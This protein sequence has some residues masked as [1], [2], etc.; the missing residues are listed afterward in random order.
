MPRKSSSVPK[1]TSRAKQAPGFLETPRLLNDEEKR[2]LIRA[3][4]A[5]RQP[6]QDPLQRLSLWAGVGLTVFVLAGGW[7]FTVGQRVQDSMDGSAEEIQ[8][9]TEELNRFSDIIEADPS[10][11]D[12]LGSMP[13]DE[14]TFADQLQDRLSA[15]R[16]RDLLSPSASTSSPFGQV[17]GEQDEVPA[18][19]TPDN[20]EE[21]SS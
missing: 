17:A 5:A 14:P 6:Q 10:L 20:E 18:G 2:E 4:M 8:R 11:Q 21:P 19:L 15:T 3:H 1:R 16:T 13:S 7:W 9:M 12:A